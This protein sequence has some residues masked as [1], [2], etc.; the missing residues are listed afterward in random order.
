MKKTK[1]LILFSLAALAICLNL[2]VLVPYGRAD[3]GPPTIYV[4]DFDD[5]SW[6]Y[7]EYPG[8]KVGIHAYT[9][10]SPYEIRVYRSPGGQSYPGPYTGAW[11]SVKNITVTTSGWFH[12]NYSDISSPGGTWWKAQIYVDGTPYESATFFVIPEV[13]LGVAA[14]LAACLASL[15]VKRL[16]HR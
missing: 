3:P 4:E 5:S 13:P 6:D 7:F 1:L 11:I 15:G 2:A 10:F 16:R 8:E 12:G 9:G 14:V